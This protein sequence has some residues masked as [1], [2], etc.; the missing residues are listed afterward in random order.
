MVFYDFEIFKFDWLVVL[1]D[2]DVETETVI[3]N[4]VDELQAFYNAHKN[5]I[6][7]GYNSRHYDQYILKCILAGL[8]PK[9]LNDWIIVQ[10][11]EGWQFSELLRRIPLINYDVMPNPPVGLKTL[12]GFM[13]ANI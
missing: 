7:V 1:V 11:K 9:E 6:W 10:R 13:G 5:D 12:E 2:T 4:D 3:H 8:N